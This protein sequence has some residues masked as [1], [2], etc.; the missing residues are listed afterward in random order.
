M[1]KLPIIRKTTIKYRQVYKPF[2]K[3]GQSLLQD[4]EI[5]MT[6]TAAEIT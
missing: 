5:T 3:K 6:G 4:I 1:Q 2:I